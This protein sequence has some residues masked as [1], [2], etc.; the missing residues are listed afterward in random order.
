[1]TDRTRIKLDEALN[2]IKAQSI[3]IIAPY[4]CSTAGQHD[5]D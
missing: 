5:I 4:E 2:L 3:M 1:M